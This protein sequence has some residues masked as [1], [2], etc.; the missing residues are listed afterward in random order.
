MYKIL[1]VEDEKITNDLLSHTLKGYGFYVDQAENGKIGLDMVSSNSYHL[2]L[3]DVIMPEM[4]GIEMIKRI[5]NMGLDTPICILTSQSEQEKQLHAF[6]LG[7]EE[8]YLKPFTAAIIGTKIKTMLNR[9]YNNSNHYN[10]DTKLEIK[11]IKFHNEIYSLSLDEYKVFKF[12]FTHKNEVIQYAKIQSLLSNEKQE[13]DKH[14][15]DNVVLKLK[16]KLG[17]N[18]RFIVKVEGVGYKYEEKFVN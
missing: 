2:I 8:Y 3:T 9:I 15:I 5:R 18:D 16:Q 10:V 11:K 1:I 17:N 7:I 14:K 12:L 4:D 6:K 13:I